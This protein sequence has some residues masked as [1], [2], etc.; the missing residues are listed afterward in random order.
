MCYP[1]LTFFFFFKSPLIQ[2]PRPCVFIHTRPL[3]QLW[4]RENW[5]QKLSILYPESYMHQSYFL[6]LLAL[7]FKALYFFSSSCVLGDWR[8][9]RGHWLPW[10]WSHTWLWTTMCVLGIDWIWVLFKSSPCWAISLALLS[11]L[12]QPY[13]LEFAKLL[14]GRSWN[15]IGSCCKG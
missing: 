11:T 15:R 14:C 8:F 7:F 10:N 9:W 2:S 1:V 5:R 4:P 3:G 6:L 12:T 13:F